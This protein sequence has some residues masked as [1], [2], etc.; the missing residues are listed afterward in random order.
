MA[1]ERDEEALDAVAHA[2]EL[3]PNHANT[4]RLKAEVLEALGREPEA[5]EALRR[6]AELEGK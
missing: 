6:A 3:R 5:Q 4:L 2:L 1:N